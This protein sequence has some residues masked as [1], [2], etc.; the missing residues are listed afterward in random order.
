MVR[1][2]VAGESQFISGFLRVRLREKSFRF[3]FGRGVMTAA[4]QCFSQITAHDR[5]AF[6]DFREGLN[7]KGDETD[8]HQKFCRPEWQAARIA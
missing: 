1:P 4:A 7:E 2:L 3:G 5:D 6:D 8:Q